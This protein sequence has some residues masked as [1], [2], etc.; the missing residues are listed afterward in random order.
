MISCSRI[1]VDKVSLWGR[2]L[3]FYEP[4]NIFM[5]PGIRLEGNKRNPRRGHIG[6]SQA[7]I[8][9]VPMPGPRNREALSL[10]N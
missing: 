5:H 10:T 8:S 7:Q 3:S 9:R 4:G 1:S 6:L 2:L